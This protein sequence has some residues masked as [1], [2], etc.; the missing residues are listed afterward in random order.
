[1][2]KYYQEHKEKALE[3]R[4]K[5]PQNSYY[6][7]NREKILAHTRKYQQRPEVKEHRNKRKQ[8]LK[9]RFETYKSG[10]KRRR[11]EWKLTFEEFKIFWQKPCYYCGKEIETI[12][13]DRINAQRD[14][15]IDNIIPC[16][17]ECNKLRGKISQEKF[18]KMCKKIADHLS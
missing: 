15:S 11:I 7:A 4:K 18:I 13:L 17:S 16:C 5:Y 9:G 2:E 8:T 12:R 6:W 10:A 3:D 1:M 14:Y